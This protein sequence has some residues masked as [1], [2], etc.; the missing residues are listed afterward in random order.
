MDALEDGIG[1]QLEGVV[2]LGRLERLI[3]LGLEISRA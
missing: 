2:D 3:S 1:V